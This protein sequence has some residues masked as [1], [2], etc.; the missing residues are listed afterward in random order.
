[1][2]FS[3][4]WVIAMSQFCVLGLLLILIYSVPFSL[5]SSLGAGLGNRMPKPLG[6]HQER[7]SIAMKENTAVLRFT[8]ELRFLYWKFNIIRSLFINASFH[9]PRR[10]TSY[11]SLAHYFAL[12][13]KE[14]FS[15]KI[16]E[17][18]LTRETKKILRQRTA[19]TSIEFGQNNDQTTAS[20]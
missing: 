2:L 19:S 20:T 7:I 11:H 4:G 13:D 1:M 14:N 15:P 18:F 5:S 3:A 10:F 17:A 9:H 12:Q 16:R 6:T 8:T